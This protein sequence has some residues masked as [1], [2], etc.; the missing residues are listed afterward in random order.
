M[1]GGGKQLSLAGGDVG[2]QAVVEAWVVAG[3]RRRGMVIT[4][5]RRG[6]RAPNARR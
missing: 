1:D 6:T 3:A 4:I 5:A 2:W